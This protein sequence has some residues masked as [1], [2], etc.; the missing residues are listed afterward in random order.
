MI[1]FVFVLPLLLIFLFGIIDFGLLLYNKAVITNACRVGARYGIVSR[2]PRYTEAEI[3]S[4]VITC[5]ENL[6]NFDTTADP[7]VST[8]WDDA[9]SNGIRDFGEDLE[10]NVTWTYT[11]LAIP[12]MP[13]IGLSDTFDISAKTVMK[14]E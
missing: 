13:G 10:V 1:E 3:R 14:Y 12:N 6:I 5:K 9:D 2:V 11:F 4:K 8:V 7:V